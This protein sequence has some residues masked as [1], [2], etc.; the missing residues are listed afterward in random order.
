LRACPPHDSATEVLTAIIA[1]LGALR[2]DVI[3]EGVE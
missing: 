1:L 3:V 2:F